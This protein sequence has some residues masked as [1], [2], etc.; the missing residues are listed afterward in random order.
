MVTHPSIVWGKK[1]SRC[2]DKNTKKCTSE[3]S[4]CTFFMRHSKLLFFPTN[5]DSFYCQVYSFLATHD[6]NWFFPFQFFFRLI[7]PLQVDIEIWKIFRN[8]KFI[9]PID[10]SRETSP[11]GSDTF[12]LNQRKANVSKCMTFSN[13]GLF[14]V[15]WV[16][17]FSFIIE[18]VKSYSINWRT[19]SHSTTFGLGDSNA[20]TF[21]GTR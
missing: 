6:E 11:I 12:D 4:K 3:K 9:F 8:V 2:E 1:A 13:Y 17:L 20:Q 5:P 14:H 21:D 16:S 10:D 7:L 15:A 18:I 19:I